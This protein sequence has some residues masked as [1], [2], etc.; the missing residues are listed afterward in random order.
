MSG[1]VVPSVLVR[2]MAMCSRSRMSTKPKQRSVRITLAFGAS[3][4]NFAIQ[5]AT[6]ISATN[7]S[8]AASSAKAAAPNVAMWN[9]IADRT[10][11]S[12]S[13]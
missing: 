3:T 5:P 8:D 4:G 7:A 13:S 1:V 12:A 11:V 2:D 6:R 10:S 9:L